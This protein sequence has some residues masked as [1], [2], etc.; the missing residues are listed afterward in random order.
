MSHRWLIVAGLLAAAC[1]PAVEAPPGLELRMSRQAVAASAALVVHTYELS[2]LFEAATPCADG[3]IVSNPDGSLLGARVTCAAVAAGVHG[4]FRDDAGVIAIDGDT[5]DALSLKR[6]T[7]PTR[8]FESDGAVAGFVGTGAILH[9]R[10][11]SSAEALRSLVGASHPALMLLDGRTSGVVYPHAAVPQIGLF[12]GLRTPIGA[13]TLRQQVQAVAGRL[14]AEV[15]ER[16]VATL[17]ALCIDATGLLET[18]APCV[19][20]HE[21]LGGLVVGFNEATLVKALAD[22]SSASSPSTL[23]VD[24][25]A[26]AAADS[27]IDGNVAW[28]I[29]NVE[30]RP[31]AA[32]NTVVMAAKAT[33][34]P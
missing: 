11:S 10:W 30:L 7:G 32:P 26:I 33:V 16:T 22:V 20:S 29:S 5:P 9:W 1:T 25:A 27:G 8:V 4:T 24:F 28:P 17:P 19:V 14:G 2:K 3:V 21:G 15:E 13:D 18:F 31:G 12:V 34:Q 6:V 23:R